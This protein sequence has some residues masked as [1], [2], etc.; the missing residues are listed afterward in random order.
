VV[1]GEV[2][3]TLKDS[4]A[5]FAPT[6]RTLSI[7]LVGVTKTFD[8]LVTAVVS[9]TTSVWPAVIFAAPAEVLGYCGDLNKDFKF[10]D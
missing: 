10:F 4:P 5:T 8:L 7:A 2:M 6:E 3:I 1:V 9:I